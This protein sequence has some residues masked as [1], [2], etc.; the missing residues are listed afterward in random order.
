[1][2]LSDMTSRVAELFRAKKF[3]LFLSLLIIAG[4]APFIFASSGSI[5]IL[6]L[7]VIFALYASSW[8]LLASSGQGSLGHAVFLA[9][10]GFASGLIAIR[11]GVPPAVSLLI[12][13]LFSA[14]IGFL[15]GLACVR[16][17]AWF[18]AMVTF[19]FA[20]IAES[21]FKQFDSVT[22]AID[23][24]R[25]QNLVAGGLPF[26]FV[27]L[28]FAGVCIS[29]M[30]L[31]SKSRIGL[32]FQAI[33]ENEAEARMIGINTGK[34][35]LIAFVL[36]TFFAGLAG[37]LYAYYLN[38]VNTSLFSA[39]FSFMPLMISVIG[40]LGTI[41]GP[42]IGS[43]ILV[44]IQEYLKTNAVTSFLQQSVGPI[45]PQVS[46]VGLPLR[47]LGIGVFLILVVIFAP[48]GVSSLIQ[49]A[50]GRIEK[51]RKGENNRER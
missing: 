26:Y 46:S 43:V 28:L 13:A 23:G 32:A 11:F 7:I 39:E 6:T 1:M 22:Q 44:S 14:G 48:K 42:I 12:G 8:N 50:Y 3:Y 45:F 25:T 29:L 30:Y 21:L 40:G 24:F 17:K 33:H 9:I 36:S 27:S 5:A 49:K 37:A 4:I 41:E 16:L 35:K 34:Y 20:V 19:G 2:P 47:L 18:L 10:G 15:V 31:M 51:R 38:F